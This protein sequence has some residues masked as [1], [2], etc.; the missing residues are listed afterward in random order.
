[1]KYKLEGVYPAI[2]TPFTKDGKNVDIDKAIGVAH[3][4]VKQGVHGLFVCGTTGEGMLL[5]LDERK[6]MV[7]ELMKAVGKKVTIIAHT[8]CFDTGSTIALT[9][10]A[11]EVGAAAVGVV[12]PGFHG[13]DN[14]SLRAHFVAVAKSVPGFPVLLYNIPGCAKNAI[15]PALVCDL[16]KR[17]DNIVG[18]K[19]SGGSIINLN[20]V[21]MDAPKDFNVINGVDEYTFQAYLAGA[22][23]S[24]SSTANVVPGLFLDIFKN[25][26]AGKLE[27]ALKAQELLSRACAL[28]QY[29][30]M[31]AFYKEG[32]RLQGVDAGFVRPPQRELN[33]GEKKALV[34]GL[35]AAGLL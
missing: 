2:V 9:R 19:D 31:V 24:V 21:L 5:S 8:G 1:M 28:F 15:S 32:L 13:Y 4:L 14:A 27:K 25:V 26:R 17:C 3:H 20:A 11:Q 23:G 29:G 35:K 16:A 30:A 33:S 34:K 22:S 10:H 18:M 6:R 12:A 7:A